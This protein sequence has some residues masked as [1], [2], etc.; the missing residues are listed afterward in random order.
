MGLSSILLGSCIALLVLF[1]FTNGFHDTA[2]MVASVVACGAMTPA[3]AILLVHAFTFLGPLLGGTA[4]ANT[5]GGLWSLDDLPSA[6][7]VGVL[8]SVTL[9][10]VLF[11]VLTWW[12]GMPSPPSHALVGRIPGLGVGYLVEEHLLDRE[13]LVAE[14]RGDRYQHRAVPQQGHHERPLRVGTGRSTT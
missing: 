12:R 9:G 2:D 10:A 14:G 7:A 5:V 3:Q 1:D 11:N 8:P 13:R 4:V 6:T